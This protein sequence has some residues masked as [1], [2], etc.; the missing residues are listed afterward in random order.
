M[1]S[2]I[3]QEFA[4]TFIPKEDFLTAL[5]DAYDNP[6]DYN[7]ALDKQ[8]NIYPG[9]GTKPWQIPSQNLKKLP[10]AIKS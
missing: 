1:T 4:S 10:A 9:R 7:F 6:K 8:G 2:I 3:L 5:S